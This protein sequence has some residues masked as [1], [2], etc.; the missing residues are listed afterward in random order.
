MNILKPNTKYTILGKTIVLLLMILFSGIPWWVIDY[1]TYLNNP[2][3]TIVS[4][5]IL[6][7]SAGIIKATT[8]HR[9]REIILVA[10][11]A[12]QI[13]LIIKMVIDGFADPSNHNMAPFEMLMIMGFDAFVCLICVYI[14]AWYNVSSI[15]K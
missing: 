8:S 4:I 5:L 15:K 6:A 2:R 1:T 14:G 10:M 9:K 13:A 7:I 11:G 12:H 3:Y